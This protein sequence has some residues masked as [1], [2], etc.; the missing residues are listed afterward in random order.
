ML[1]TEKDKTGRGQCET[2]RLGHYGD[3]TGLYNIQYNIQ[4]RI[5]RLAIL[6]LGNHI[7]K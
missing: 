7:M 6:K 2:V 3:S 5:R 4:E 1:R